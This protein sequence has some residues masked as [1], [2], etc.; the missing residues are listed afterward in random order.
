MTQTSS[1]ISVALSRALNHSASHLIRQ[2][3]FVEHLLALQTQLQDDLVQ[4]GS[5]ARGLI[6]KILGE[7]ERRVLR[8]NERATAAGNAVEAQSAQLARVR[9]VS[10]LCLS[11]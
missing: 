6:S 8:V 11:P 1:N 7:V 3:S 10:H 4:A 5:D 2:K 9:D